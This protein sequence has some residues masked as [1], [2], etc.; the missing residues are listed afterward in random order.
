MR[1]LNSHRRSLLGSLTAGGVSQLA[2][3]V[4]GVLVAR[5][6]GANDRGYFAFILLVPHILAQL[7]TLGVP[8]AITYFAARR[9]RATGKI[10]RAAAAPVGLQL[11][12]CVVLQVVVLAILLRH[13]PSRVQF[14]GA[15]SLGLIPG[16]FALQYGLAVLQGQQRFRPFNILRVMPS[17]MYS[18]G[19]LA[20][21]VFGAGNLIAITAVQVGAVD[22]VGAAVLYVAWKGV[23][24]GQ[25]QQWRSVFRDRRGVG[26]GSRSPADD[27]SPS[28]RELISF[29]AR[30]L[31]GSMS[32]VETFRI[33][34]AVI[35]L[36][37]TPTALGLY[38]VGVSITNLPRFLTQSVG[39]VAYP[40]IASASA[41]T[42]KYRL[43]WRYFWIA[44]GITIVVVV[45]LE[46]MA[47]VLI[48]FF[49]G[50]EF[51][52]SVPIAQ[53]LL[54][55]TVA[56]GCRRV[57]AD[58][59]RGAGYPG[60]GT[61]AEVVAW[62]AL[63]PALAILVPTM[64]INGVALALAI[65]WLVSF[66]LIAAAILWMQ[67]ARSLGV[68]ASPTQATLETLPRTPVLARQADE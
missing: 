2:L 35:G 42:V 46:M 26:R 30:G 27:Q 14:A 37:L 44:L 20:V 22:L 31:L 7:G 64:G 25:G 1:W 45:P 29:G 55:G 39:M 12:G 52:R 43:I 54:A 19:V 13:D 16:L 50:R 10:I 56:L 61:F 3:I 67:S 63:A 68:S 17:A 5:S 9:P 59:A 15:L 33:D 62:M 38:V 60:L 6:L 24:G 48:P 41:T 4:G 21:Y 53:I 36:F 49:F 28:R 34:Q 11:I 23:V 66:I 51:A 32:A 18:F 8:L 47:N 57:L 40:A 58:G 65:S